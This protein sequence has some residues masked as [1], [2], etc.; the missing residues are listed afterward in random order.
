MP[1]LKAV[2]MEAM[3]QHGWTC[4]MHEPNLDCDDC[5]RLYH[6]LAEEI[7]EALQEDTR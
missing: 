2:V 5:Q 7:A 4:D 6:E 1:D 3:F